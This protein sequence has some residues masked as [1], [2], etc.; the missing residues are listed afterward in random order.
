MKNKKNSNKKMESTIGLIAAIIILL[1]A[2]NIDFT[3]MNFEFSLK[4]LIYIL[5][6]FAAIAS[7]AYVLKVGND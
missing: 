3:N 4:T 1:I 6:G 2:R 5:I 7:I